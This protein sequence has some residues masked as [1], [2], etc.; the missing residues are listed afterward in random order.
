[1]GIKRKKTT[2]SLN[3]KQRFGAQ[4]HKMV[5]VEHLKLAGSLMTT[6]IWAHS[7]ISKFGSAP[8]W[9]EVHSKTPPGR[10][11]TADSTKPYIYCFSYT[12]ILM[13]KFYL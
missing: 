6:S 10:P 5:W 13:I 4:I 3:K 2:H 8:V 11:E 12:S 1:M 9:Q 7:F